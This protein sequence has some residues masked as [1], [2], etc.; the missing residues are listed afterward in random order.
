MD[1]W[2][3]EKQLMIIMIK[4][5]WEMPSRLIPRPEPLSEDLNITDHDTLQVFEPLKNLSSDF[6]E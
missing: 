5:F 6:Y 3:D 4:R 1:G 2:P